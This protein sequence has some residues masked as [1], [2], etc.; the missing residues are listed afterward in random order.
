MLEVAQNCE[1]I[2]SFF[3][4]AAVV[5]QILVAFL[6][7]I[8]IWSRNCLGHDHATEMPPKMDIILLCYTLGEEKTISFYFVVP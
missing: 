7:L 5:I 2:S 1:K 8:S 3:G 4:R 6:H